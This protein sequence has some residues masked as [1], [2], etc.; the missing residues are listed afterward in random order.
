MLM[1]SPPDASVE[2]VAPEMAL[3]ALREAGPRT[4]GELLGDVDFLLTAI[5]REP[6]EM[7]APGRRDR[8]EYATLLARVEEA[9][10]SLDALEARTIVALAEA[11]RRD[12]VAVA[13]ERA[14]QEE[15]AVP[16]LDLLHRRAD[17]KTVR[18]L[19]LTL[20]AA[21]S[22]SRRSLA[23]ARRL[24]DSM[25]ATLEALATGQITAAKSYATANVA[26][27]LDPERR[28]VLDEALRQAMPQLDGAGVAQWRKEV[29]ALIS[30]LDPAGE[31]DRHRTARRERHVTLTPGEHGMATLSAYLPALEANLVRKRLSLEAERRRAEGVRE[32]HSALMADA[33]VQTLLG[34]DEAMDPVTLDVGVVITDRALLEP[35][36]GD[37]AQIEGYG[38]VPVEAVRQ[39]LRDALTEPEDPRRD[40]DGPHGPQLRAV[41]RRLY[42]H[43]STGELVAVESRAEVFPPALKRFLLWRD[44]SCRAPYCDAPARHADHIHPRRDGGPTSIDNGQYLCAAC[45]LG[46]EDDSRSVERVG[47]ASRTVAG[48]DAAAAAGPD[49]PGRVI[50]GRSLGG[51]VRWTGHSGVSAVSVAPRLSRTVAT[52]SATTAQPAAETTAQVPDSAGTEVT[53]S[54]EALPASSASLKGSVHPGAA[55]DSA[56]ADIEIHGT[57]DSTEPTV[58]SDTVACAPAPLTLVRRIPVGDGGG[59]GPPARR[60]YQ[61]VR[62]R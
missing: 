51:A 19:S 2:P 1:Q 12:E 40:P 52:F 53:V 18:D 41:L 36:R 21:P 22:T 59:S 34:R 44:G 48:Q 61:P 5:A 54:T 35:Q 7:F 14:A 60:T 55:G 57:V 50:A 24:V 47:D 38:P 27:P 56:L 39:G 3:H 45:N 49:A 23:A 8:R 32:G 29:G 6:R 4:L 30:E 9:R 33:L 11:T 20:R 43:P 17:G 13:Q 15:E 25:P 62:C 46:K 58:A 10:S 28:R 42:T 16:P 37:P 26:A 31:T